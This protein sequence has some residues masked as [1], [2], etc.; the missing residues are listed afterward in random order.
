MINQAK[1]QHIN[2][3]TSKDQVDKI[4]KYFETIASKKCKKNEEKDLIF[5]TR[6]TTVV[7]NIDII[8]VSESIKYPNSKERS[9]FMVQDHTYW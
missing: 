3:L 1:K 5:K 9:L 4:D 2:F 8:E 6:K 7:I